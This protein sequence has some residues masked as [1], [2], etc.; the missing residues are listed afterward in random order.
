MTEEQGGPYETEDMKGQGVRL[1]AI[2]SN[3]WG[4]G[5]TRMGTIVTVPGPFPCLGSWP[6]AL[7]MDL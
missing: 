7:Y 5:A 3:C 4:P 2:A 6:A 1:R